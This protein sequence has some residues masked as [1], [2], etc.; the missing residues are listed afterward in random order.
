MQA[1]RHQAVRVAL[2]PKDSVPFGVWKFPIDER[3]ESVAQSVRLQGVGMTGCL[4]QFCLVTMTLGAGR[5]SQIRR[6]QRIRY[7]WAGMVASLGRC[8]RRAERS[9]GSQSDPRKDG[10]TPPDASAQPYFAHE[11]AAEFFNFATKSTRL[12]LTDS[13]VPVES[14][15]LPRFRHSLPF[16]HSRAGGNPVF[17]F[18][19]GVLKHAMMRK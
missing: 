10:K 7:A 4:V 5:I 19:V 13:S 17:D 9:H 3:G 2:E 12:V 6:P 18:T 14:R 16:R 11:I 15:H 1:F 8:D